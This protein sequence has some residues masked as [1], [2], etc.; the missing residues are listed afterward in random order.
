M[1]ETY[2]KSGTAGIEG[3]LYQIKLLTLFLY[4]GIKQCYSF[5]LATEMENA[6]KFDDIVFK[7]SNAKE[8]EESLCLQAKHRLDESKK[9]CYEDLLTESAG[10]YSLVKYFFSYQKTIEKKSF[11]VIKEV[12]VYTNIALAD[13]VKRQVK[14]VTRKENEILNLESSSKSSKHYKFHKDIIRELKPKL[15]NY[16]LAKL[17]VEL[18]NHLL[19]KKP[20]TIQ[21]GSIFADYEAIIVTEVFDVRDE[22]IQFYD[23]FINK[24]QDLASNTRRFQEICEQVLKKNTNKF[25]YVLKNEMKNFNVFEKKNKR[26]MTEVKKLI[27]LRELMQYFENKT[28]GADFVFNLKDLNEFTKAME[29][30]FSSVVKRNSDPNVGWPQ[31]IADDQIENFL[32]HLVFAVDQPNEVELGNIIESEVSKDSKFKDLTSELVA[33]HIQRKMLQWFKEKIGDKGRFLTPAEGRIFL[34]EITQKID[35][36]IS[37]GSSI[38]YCGRLKEY[39]L[40]FKHNI[41]D[42]LKNFLF[43]KSS[44]HKM[45]YFIT[46]QDSFLSTIKLYQVLENEKYDNF[47]FV[48]LSS[49]LRSS[50]QQNL[51]TV[52]HS[53]SH[54][55]LVIEGNIDLKNTLEL[56]DKLSDIIIN[57]VKK[58]VLITKQN[59]TLMNKFV[60][61]P[62]FKGK[63]ESEQ[64]TTSFTDLTQ[65]SQSE[66]LEREVMF[67]GE[68]IML[69][70]LID[71]NDENAKQLIDLDT[72]MKLVKNE[73]ITIGK[74]PPLLKDLEAAYARINEEVLVE[75]LVREL[76]K[77]S[78]PPS[79]FMITGI[80]QNNIEAVQNEVLR[81]LKVEEGNNAAQADYIRQ[82][83]AAA[84]TR[85]SVTLGR[86]KEHHIQSFKSL[87]HNNPEKIVYWIEVTSQR[88]HLRQ[89]YNPNFY[90]R[91]EFNYQEKIIIKDS[92]ENELTEDKPGSL[93]LFTG[94]DKEGL[95]KIFKLKDQE[96][97]EKLKRNT[98]TQKQ[99]GQE[100]FD[101]LVK[102]GNGPVHWLHFEKSNDTNKRFIWRKSHGSLDVLRKHI[103]KKPDPYDETKFIEAI[104]D[105][106]VIL[107][108]EPGMGK[109][110]TLTSLSE[111]KIATDWVI[112]IDFKDCQDRIALLP[113]KH[114]QRLYDVDHVIN[115]LSAIESSGLNS[116]LTKRLFKYRLQKPKLSDHQP[117]LLLFDGFDEIIND[118][119]QETVIFLLKFLKQ[120]TS[121]SIW[122]CTR[123]YKMHEL[124]NG[125]SIFATTFEEFK[126]EQQKQFLNVYWQVHL[127]LMSNENSEQDLQSKVELYAKALLEKVA[128]IFGENM[129]RFMGI[130]LQLRLLAEGFQRQV[131]TFTNGQGH[132]VPSFEALN[133]V[134]IYKY[135]I[136][137]KYDVYFKEKTHLDS[138]SPYIRNKLTKC[139]NKDHQYLA[140]KVLFPNVVQT[141]IELI[142]GQHELLAPEAEDCLKSVG[143]IQSVGNAK[144]VYFIHKTFA[145]Y[146]AATLFTRSLEK[147]MSNPSKYESVKSFL[148]GEIFKDSNEVVRNFIDRI[149]AQNS[150][151]HVAT[152]DCNLST[153]ND[154]LYKQ[155]IDVTAVDRLGRTALHLAVQTGSIHIVRVLLAAGSNG[156]RSDIF[157]KTSLHYASRYGH[158]EISEY[159]QSYY[160]DID[161]NDHI[162]RTPLQIDTVV[163]SSVFNEVKYA[164]SQLVNFVNKQDNNGKTCLYYAAEQKN[165]NLACILLLNGADSNAL[166]GEK[167]KKL[168]LY[169]SAQSRS[170]YA[171][172]FHKLWPVVGLLSLKVPDAV[173]DYDEGYRYPRLLSSFFVH[174]HIKVVDAL[175]GAIADV[176]KRLRILNK[177]D[178]SCTPLDHVNNTVELSDS[179][180]LQAIKYLLGHGATNTM[181]NVNHIYLTLLSAASQG[182]IETFKYVEN[183]GQKKDF[184]TYIG[185]ATVKNRFNIVKYL[186]ENCRKFTTTDSGITALH[187]AADRGNLKMIKYL[188]DHGANVNT[189]ASDGRTPLHYAAEEKRLDVIKYLV[190]KGA[191]INIATKL[192]GMT[193]LDYALKQCIFSPN[194]VS[195]PKDEMGSIKY[196]ITECHAN[197]GS[198]SDIN[199]ATARKIFRATF[200]TVNIANQDGE[201][202]LHT[203]VTSGEALFV[204]FLLK[205]GANVNAK[206]NYGRTP[207]HLAVERNFGHIAE[208]LLQYGAMYDATD[209]SSKTPMDLLKSRFDFFLSRQTID[210]LSLIDSLFRSKNLMQDLDDKLLNE[211]NFGGLWHPDVYDPLNPMIFILNARNAQGSTLLHVGADLNDSEAIK[212]LLKFNRDYLT[213]RDQMA[214]TKDYHSMDLTVKDFRG[215]TP[216]HRAAQHGSSEI[217][218]LLVKE[219][220]DFSVKNNKGDLPEHLA[221]KNNHYNV[222]EVLQSTK[223][224]FDAIEKNNIQVVRNCI[225]KGANINAIDKNGK[226]PFQSAARKNQVE[227]VNILLKNEAIFT[228]EGIQNEAPIDFEEK[229]SINLL[230]AIDKAFNGVQRNNSKSIIDYL[231]RVKLCNVDYLSVIV[232]TRD[233]QGNTLL[234]YAAREDYFDLVQFLL[235]NKAAYD[236]RNTQNKTPANFA[237]RQ[238][239]INLLHFIDRL[240]SDQCNTV[241]VH[242]NVKLIYSFEEI[243]QDPKTLGIIT[244]AR[245][246]D[247]QTILHKNS[248]Y[249]R[250]KFLVRNGAEIDAVDKDGK[251][252]L[253]FVAQKGKLELAKWLIEHGAQANATDN[254]GNTV[255][256]EAASSGQLDLITWLVEKQCVSVDT[257][258]EH[259]HTPTFVAGQNGHGNVVRYL[260]DSSTKC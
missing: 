201:T 197:V 128:G 210:L 224:L 87:C 241:V 177:G 130:P 207:L 235:Q 152:L 254:R 76:S 239:I 192:N 205:Q 166:N 227:I 252:A 1:E 236:V 147:K 43:G 77:T 229:K 5:R 179:D 171:Y 135:F 112:R 122:V 4:R 79:L 60:N 40:E 260:I 56:Y 38:E 73:V 91:R 123:P 97:E 109:T 154:L 157:G 230:D 253:H 65:I 64:D 208:L 32:D 243:E 251:T 6:G 36:L 14:P 114:E 92:I 70:R 246:K 176:E 256:H 175:L 17:A 110:T 19:D 35:S 217:V 159:L 96:K 93:F 48:E 173:L 250:L 183:Q 50:K 255:L 12:I 145:E 189:A 7:Y 30:K 228:A 111:Q 58:V 22:Y 24:T 164:Q 259:G 232:N 194:V 172:Q 156:L 211:R 41:S 233:S 191:Q 68:V 220:A 212:C 2:R 245:N 54:R 45:L 115:F 83:V 74:S 222:V 119:Y 102:N 42:D 127:T 126:S 116:Q 178:N 132:S 216:L 103:D 188:C 214:H 167:Q 247:G 46:S 129:S 10:D 55:L 202:F 16:K 72:L 244:N 248:N 81:K 184:N 49:L 11:G 27:K 181:N 66:L 47:L 182:H 108:D 138:Y 242:E 234:H 221:Q 240:Y 137:A 106:V 223:D 53:Y 125:L 165:W 258:N 199:I 170:A 180:H 25:K 257:K 98:I 174:G 105:Q 131:I 136:E 163:G 226:S 21:H 34:D 146:F 162:F 185:I 139:F 37:I 71:Q 67:Q 200:S 23:K 118:E 203:A 100:K 140:F 104:K 231:Q 26:T 144:N 8:T 186:W 190:S 3:S 101:E 88:V 99:N 69:N 193:V 142:F 219:G 63:F 94:L 158:A 121:A 78:D 151:I 155:C 39:N 59:D 61:D 160:T 209:K 249:Y 150:P 57:S 86:N 225:S 90:L 29:V 134:D 107:V 13:D 84:E 195:Y 113:T 82:Q 31:T 161:I 80:D 204:K 168:L 44:D 213:V 148:F 85:I 20:I 153:I 62:K 15:E 28:L 215:D 51:T 143:I 33:D 206:N 196:L 18:I 238:D 237:F 218:A 75:N 89:I 169:A 9:I 149:L 52:L 117:I 120:H 124:E 95:L 198:R 187:Y 141:D 133:I